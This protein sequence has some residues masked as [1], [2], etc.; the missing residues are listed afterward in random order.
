[1]DEMLTEGF[2]AERSRLVGLATKVLGDRVEAEDVGP[3]GR[4]PGCTAP[5]PRSRS[6]RA[7]S[8]SSP[9]GRA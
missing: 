3:A 4:G 7:G 6:C 5:G 8:S 2:E 1:M 9:R